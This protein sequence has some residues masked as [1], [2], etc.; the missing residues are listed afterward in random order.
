VATGV[1]RANQL[2][3][4]DLKGK[5]DP[6]WCPGCGD[7]GVLAAIQKALIEL[8]IPTHNVVTISGIGCSS[9]LPGRSHLRF[10]LIDSVQR[11]LNS[12]ILQ[13]AL[14]LVV[15]DSGP[16][17]LDR[18]SRLAKLRLVVV[19]LELDE[20]IFRAHSLKIRDLHTP[21]DACHFC[22]Q[23]GQVTANERVIRD[24]LDA[25]ALP[26]IPVSCD[27]NYHCCCEQQHK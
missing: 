4:A 17:S 10:G 20:Q 11:S 7:F 14:L 24:L 21:D 22:A 26:G 16:G 2:T 1:Q 23:W 9:N 27:G 18:S 19:V 3:I 12:R 8:R 15:L 6:D 25:A 5:V 13:F